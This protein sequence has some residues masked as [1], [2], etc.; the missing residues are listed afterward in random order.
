M[1][2]FEE[3]SNVKTVSSI[4]QIKPVEE[5]DVEEELKKKDPPPA[6]IVELAGSGKLVASL[7]GR[8]K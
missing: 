2:N 3:I 5:E 1:Q 4:L 7:F 8:R 6:R